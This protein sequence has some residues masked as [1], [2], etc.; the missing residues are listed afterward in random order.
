MKIFSAF[1]ITFVGLALLTT[2]ASADPTGD[3]NLFGAAE[4]CRISTAGL[5]YSGD[6]GF[7]SARQN[8]LRSRQDCQQ[9]S[10]TVNPL[11]G[12]RGSGNQFNY[13]RPSRA[14]RGNAYRPGRYAQGNVAY[15]APS[16]LGNLFG[17]AE[18]CRISTTGIPY[19]GG[20]DFESARQTALRSRQDCSQVANTVS[21]ITRR[22]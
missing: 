13:H 15:N 16:N 1:A 2:S 6:S 14:A 17:A 12:R 5:P 8:A 22:P 4:A 20:S 11:T 7:E 18:V 10:D 9:V 21:Q 3:G 19:I